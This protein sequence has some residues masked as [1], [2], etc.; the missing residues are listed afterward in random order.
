M[1]FEKCY[2]G[3]SSEEVFVE[4]LDF[5]GSLPDLIET[6]KKRMIT[7]VEKEL[8]IKELSRKID[9]FDFKTLMNRKPSHLIDHLACKLGYSLKILCPPVKA[10]LLCKKGLT[11][12]HKPSQVIVHKITGPEIYSKFLYRCREC[13]LSNDDSVQNRKSKISIMMWISMEIPLQVGYFTR[14]MILRILRP[15]M[16]CSWTET[17]YNPTQMIYVMLG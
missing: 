13:K 8:K 9:E 3:L 17:L 6:E 12:N 15:V 1:D 2:S 5:L 14:C 4:Y 11:V 7:V 16:K 10:C